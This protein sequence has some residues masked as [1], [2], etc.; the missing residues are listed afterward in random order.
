[1]FLIVFVAGSVVA[2]FASHRW[3]ERPAQRAVQRLADRWKQGRPA[4]V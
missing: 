4:T 3:I 1:V 2:G